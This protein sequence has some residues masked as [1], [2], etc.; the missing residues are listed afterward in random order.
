M[1]HQLTISLPKHPY[2]RKELS[3][4]WCAMTKTEKCRYIEFDRTRIIEARS[5]T[6]KIEYPFETNSDDHCETC[7]TAYKDI[8][9]ILQEFAKLCGKTTATLRIYDPYYCAGAV[10]Q[11]LCALGFENVY[12]KCEDF[13]KVIKKKKTPAFDVLVTNPPYS[14]KHVKRL[15]QFCSK[16][17]VPCLLL[18]PNHIQAKDFFPKAE[19]VMLK[20]KRRYVYW[21]PKGLRSKA[22]QQNHACA[23]GFRTS[24][25]PT[26]WY[27]DTKF[28]AVDLKAIYSD[29]TSLTLQV[30]SSE[31][32]SSP[33][34]PG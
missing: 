6:E 5:K 4:D 2:Y 26:S 30:C 17:S 7:P 25:F 15:L 21:T 9:P 14:E 16:Q 33:T 8:V 32:G 18:M 24:P 20:P 31:N 28:R 11:H 1:M 12:N 29:N 19:Y 22:K 10:V 27:C 34:F 3:Q 13:Y 23:K